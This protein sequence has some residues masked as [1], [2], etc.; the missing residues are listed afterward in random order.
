[1]AIIEL[2]H[3]QLKNDITAD[4]PELR[5]N[6]KEVKRLIEKYSGLQTL[7]YSQVDD[8]TVIF[9]IAAWESKDKHQHVFVESPYQGEIMNL[10]RDQVEVDWTYCMDVEQTKIPLDAPVLAIIKAVL[11]IHTRKTAFD[12]DFAS[13][14]K[15]LCG[16]RYGAISA[17][18]IRKDHKEIIV[19]TD[20]S[21]WESVDEATEAFVNA[22]ETAKV[23]R[24]DPI[25]L[26]LFFT[27]RM[28][29]D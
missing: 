22:I 16:A 17:W 12:Q 10:I 13:K 3:C 28:Y 25:E 6:L 26:N 14:T 19:R 20:F 24:V 21:G 27:E 11:P 4:N 9:L 18:N 23:F 5:K 8:P 15:T 7:F 1:M 2:A 29:L